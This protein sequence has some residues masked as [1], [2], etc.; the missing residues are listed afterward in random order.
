MTK[1]APKKGGSK[2]RKPRSRSRG[3]GGAKRAA[4]AAAER[5]RWQSLIARM[6]VIESRLGISPDMY[7][8]SDEE[9]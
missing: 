3:Q 7:R 2:G 4:T 8:P 1:Y 6:S 5:K 9:E